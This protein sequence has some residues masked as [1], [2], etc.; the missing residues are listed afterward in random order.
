MAGH[1]SNDWHRLC[2]V[3]VALVVIAVQGSLFNDPGESILPGHPE[4]MITVW[5]RSDCTWYYVL[6]I[7]LNWCGSINYFT[8]EFEE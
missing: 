4:F 1:F 2:V 3:A 6:E 5:E 8:I 7:A